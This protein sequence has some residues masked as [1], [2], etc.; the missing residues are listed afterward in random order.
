MKN[1]IIFGTG[2]LGKLIHLYLKKDSSHEVVA[3]T[4]NEWALKNWR[5]RLFKSSAI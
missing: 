1:V 2:D 3:F 5:K 4:V